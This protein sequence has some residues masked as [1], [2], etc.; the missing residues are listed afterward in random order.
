VNRIVGDMQLPEEDR[1][2]WMPANPY[3]AESPLQSSG[4]LGPVTI[5]A[6]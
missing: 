6:F 5:K 2:I 1:I 4:L 3:D